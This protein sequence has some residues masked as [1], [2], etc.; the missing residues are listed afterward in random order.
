M[1]NPSSLQL[2]MGGEEGDPDHPPEIRV[3]DLIPEAGSDLTP[4]AGLSASQS[5]AS[6]D[7][8]EEEAPAAWKGL[9]N[10]IVKTVKALLKEEAG[11]EYSGYRGT[12]D[13]VGSCFRSDEDNTNTRHSKQNSKQTQHG[14]S[15]EENV[16]SAGKRYGPFVEERNMELAVYG[17]STEEMNGERAGSRYGPSMEE[18]NTERAGKQYGPSMEE[19]NMK[20]CGKRDGPS[21]EEINTERAGKRYGPSMQEI[22]QE[23]AESGPSTE[24]RAGRNIWR[25]K[26]GHGP[27]RWAP[28]SG[29]D[30]NT[31][32]SAEEDEEESNSTFVRMKG[33]KNGSQDIATGSGTRNLKRRRSGSREALIETVRLMQAKLPRLEKGSVDKYWAFKQQFQDFVLDSATTSA[34]YKLNQLYTNCDGEVQTLI[35]HC[36]ALPAGRA[37]KEALKILD[38]HFGDERTYM[39]QSRERILTGPTIGEHDYQA[40]TQLYAQLT[41]LLSFA[42]NMGY[43]NEVDNTPTIRDIML[44]LDDAMQTRWNTYWSGKKGKRSQRVKDVLKFVKKETKRIESARR[45]KKK[46]N[47][48]TRK[49]HGREQERRE[50]TPGNYRRTQSYEEKHQSRSQFKP[51]AREVCLTT[52]TRPYVKPAGPGGSRYDANKCRLCGSGHSLYMCPLFRSLS[53]EHRRS[54]V[55]TQGRCFN[56]LGDT[57]LVKDCKARPC[58]IDNCKGWHSR[59]LHESTSRNLSQVKGESNEEPEQRRM[60]QALDMKN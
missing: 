32:S 4:E 36:M 21:V 22:N 43:L 27:S 7:L 13:E 53:V 60:S 6:S 25:N 48:E 41:A 39:D 18:I 33:R 23:R 9:R 3:N 46:Y 29:E 52:Q 11:Q 15:S 59:W 34:G 1:S 2:P 51:R 31:G 40:L 10:F 35:S 16:E 17:P 56:C 44:R 50:E 38:D 47:T 19:I 55:R 26:G 8:V 12:E 45:L 5:Q 49:T 28:S 30:S 20:C 58:D 24:K 42:K 37:L 54:I 14:P 57:H